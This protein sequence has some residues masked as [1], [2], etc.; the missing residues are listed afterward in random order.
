MPTESRNPEL[1]AL[2]REPVDDVLDRVSRETVP[3]SSESLRLPD[4]ADADA[5][6]PLEE[7]IT[8]ESRVSEGSADALDQVQLRVRVEL[9]RKRMSLEDALELS[10]GDVIDLQKSVESPVDVFV[11]E[12]LV[13]G[14]PLRCG[15]A[16]FYLR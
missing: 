1:F 12:L 4:L 16:Y 8:D 6:S 5:L 9:G 14:T 10:A 7:P 2:D 13:A 3:G 15:P 11:G